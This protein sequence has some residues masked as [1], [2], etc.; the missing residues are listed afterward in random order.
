MTLA[1]EK[2]AQHKWGFWASQS[3]DKSLQRDVLR[4]LRGIR[5]CERTMDSLY[6]CWWERSIWDGHVAAGLA[7]WAPHHRGVG[8]Q[9]NHRQENQDLQ[10]LQ[11]E[12]RER[13][14]RGV[15]CTS[16]CIPAIGHTTQRKGLCPIKRLFWKTVSPDS[17]GVQGFPVPPQNTHRLLL[18]SLSFPS[19]CLKSLTVHSV[20][21]SGECI[22]LTCWSPIYSYV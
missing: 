8:W 1:E 4:L 16:V 17:Y 15:A 12:Q 7:V 21:Q 5:V 3:T 19:G 9:H 18:N 13:Q 20:A 10:H 22:F 6:W 14:R 2:V 11:S